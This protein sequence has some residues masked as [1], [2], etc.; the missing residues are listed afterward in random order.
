M[1]DLPGIIN[2]SDQLTKNLGWILRSRH[3]RGSNGTLQSLVDSSPFLSS[4]IYPSFHNETFHAL[5]GGGCQCTDDST[6]TFSVPFFIFLLVLLSP[7]SHASIA[8]FSDVSCRV[9]YSHTRGHFALCRRSTP[10]LQYCSSQTLHYH[11]CL[12]SVVELLLPRDS[13]PDSHAR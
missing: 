11:L 6:T 5:I 3:A 10:L 8:S 13:I 4:I 12:T 9:S 1:G 2:P 7:P